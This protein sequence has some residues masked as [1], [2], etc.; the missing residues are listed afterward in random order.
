ML[1]QHVGANDQAVGAPF[2]AVDLFGAGLHQKVLVSTDGL[3]AQHLVDD[4]Q[5]PIRM[6][7]QGIIDEAVEVIA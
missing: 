1:C 6:F 5:S 4:D 7:V 3:G 2:V